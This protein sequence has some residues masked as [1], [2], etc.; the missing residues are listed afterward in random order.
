MKQ[1][2]ALFT[3]VSSLSDIFLLCTF[4]VFCRYFYT[5]RLCVLLKSNLQ[6]CVANTRLSTDLQ[7]HVHFFLSPKMLQ[8][9]FFGT[10]IPLFRMNLI[11]PLPKSG[12]RYSVDSRRFDCMFVNK[13]A[14]KKRC[15][16]AICLG[17]PASCCRNWLETAGRGCDQN[18]Y[19]CLCSGCF[20]AI[21][22]RGMTLAKPRAASH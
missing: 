14:N 9:I 8:K 3:V 6:F 11:T 10:S 22:D 15:H 18:I 2:M 5:K 12:P 17:S 16:M 4:N 21:S 1:S 19:M 7:E 13:L 20:D